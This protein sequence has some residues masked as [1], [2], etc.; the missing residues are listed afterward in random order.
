MFRWV[1]YWYRCYSAVSSVRIES[2]MRLVFIRS[3]HVHD[4]IIWEFVFCDDVSRR[5]ESTGD[6]LLQLKTSHNPP[7]SKKKGPAYPHNRGDP[8]D[9]TRINLVAWLSCRSKL[10][11][12]WSMNFHLVPDGT[13]CAQRMRHSL[14]LHLIHAVRKHYVLVKSRPLST[15]NVERLRIVAMDMKFG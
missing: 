10:L 6:I 12:K 8:H 1:G 4:N 9:P 13:R 2:G 3:R 15:K 7:F 14:P 11:L 5:H